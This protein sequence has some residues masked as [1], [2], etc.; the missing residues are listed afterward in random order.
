MTAKDEE[1]E[2]LRAFKAE[3][4]AAEKKRKEDEAEREKMSWFG[5]IWDMVADNFW[6]IL[7]AV[8][9]FVV[10]GPEKMKELWD[11]GTEMLGNVVDQVI[12]ALPQEWQAGLNAFLG[13]DM[14][15]A[16][17]DMANKD[18]GELKKTLVERGNIPEAVVKVVAPNKETFLQFI[19][20]V[21][22]AND[23]RDA[24]GNLV[25]RGKVSADTMT[26]D[27]TI[28]ALM[29]D[30][31]QMVRD[32]LT[33]LPKEEAGKESD[34]SKN[35]KRAMTAIINSDK[36]D[37]LLSPRHFDE[38][39]KTLQAVAAK[40]GVESIKPDALRNLI[41]EQ[42]DANGKPTPQLRAMLS[43]AVA[44]DVESMMRTY[45]QGKSVSELIARADP[46]IMTPEAQAALKAVQDAIAT[47]PAAKTALDALGA[48]MGSE[49]MG[50]L[51]S[52]FT[53]QGKAGLLSMLTPA[54]IGL[55]PELHA[56]V[57]EVPAFAKQLPFQ[58][59]TL[60]SFIQATGMKDG[61][62]NAALTALLGSVSRQPHLSA[63][64]LAQPLKDYILSPEVA[65]NPQAVAAVQAFAKELDTSKLSPSARDML[66]Q[67]PQLTPTALIALSNLKA[68]GIADP[69][70]LKD[71]LLVKG[72]DGK[73]TLTA[74][75]ALDILMNGPQRDQLRK[76]GVAENLAALANEFAPATRGTITGANLSA[77]LTFADATATNNAGNLN[78][79][80][81]G[82]KIMTALVTLVSD[83]NAKP[84]ANLHAS[85]IAG[86]FTTKGNAAAVA[87]LLGSIDTSGMA[88]QQKDVIE[89]LRNNY[90]G[91]N[92][93]GGLLPVLQ[94]EKAVKLLL[95]HVAKA[96]NTQSC[97]AVEESKDILSNDWLG[98]FKG[99][100]NNLGAPKTISDNATE[101]NAI[102]RALAKANCTAQE[103]SSAPLPPY[104]LQQSGQIGAM[105]VP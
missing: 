31:P 100:L 4:D 22:A 54:N 37:V 51:A 18:M 61:Q 60:H 83:P 97:S 13:R 29:R 20:D 82:E 27:K 80:R 33:A 67:L 102:A 49:K 35:V 53:T 81:N 72:A 7:L 2:R 59:D 98:N 71:T 93:T 73:L 55:L 88:T 46:S 85:E 41:R 9:A 21:R 38:T 79:Q 39:M 91:A 96:K 48:K 99:S 87:T 94:D 65:K 40:M 19:G 1:L 26:N 24:A 78:H 64:A 6:L 68:A 75:K 90:I 16:L 86:F 103:G 45:M 23:E 101:V 10:I 89:A 52:A 56:F 14:H 36:L 74:T 44:G 57:K 50:Q 3:R 42:L 76:A 32:I 84:F 15:D 70:A 28:F 25:R 69:F 8:V 47:N 95:E 63:D 30:R 105:M 5:R 62:P 17:A 58:L 12:E 34:I 77:I 11:K 66:A 92:G 104:A 43:A